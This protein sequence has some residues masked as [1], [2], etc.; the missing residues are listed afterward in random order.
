MQCF[1]AFSVASHSDNH[2]HPCSGVMWESR[3]ASHFPVSAFARPLNV[4]PSSASCLIA[5][6]RQRNAPIALSNLFI[7]QACTRIYRPSC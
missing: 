4:E 2:V 6:F 7:A 3:S 5:S 1:P